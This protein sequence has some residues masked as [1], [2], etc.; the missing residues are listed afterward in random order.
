MKEFSAQTGGRY[1]YADDLENLQD[2]ALAFAQIFDD[3]D[4]FIVSGCE[5]AGSAISAGYVFLN[6]KLRHFSGSADITSW[7]QYIYEANS[8]ENIPYES[9]GSKVGRNIYGCAIAKTV[10]VKQDELT[11][12][13]IQSIAISSTGGL[14]MKDAFIGKYAL[15]LDPESGSQTVNSIVN[16]IKAINANSDFTA[17]KSVTIKSGAIKTEFSYS[18]ST[19]NVKYTG[20]SNNYRLSLID[21]VGFRFYADE[22]LIATIGN[23]SIDFD[24]PIAASE[25]EFG[26]LALTGNHFYQGAAN[27]ISEIGINVHGYKGGDSQFRNTNIGNGKGKILL[28]IT[29]ADGTVN[30]FGTTKIEAGTTD[31]LVLKANALKDNIGLTNAISWRDS[32]NVAM[33]SVGFLSTADQVFSVSVPSYNIGITGHATVDIGPAIMENGELLSEKY[34]LAINFATEFNKKANVEDV[35]TIAQANNTFAIKTDGLSQFVSDTVTAADCRSHIGAVG[36]NDLQSYAKLTNYLSDMATTDV[37]KKKIRDNIG[38]AGV[39]DFQSKLTDSGWKLIKD[40]LY[41]RQIGNIVC[42]QGATRTVHSGTVF[43]IPNTIA[44]PSHAVKHSIA[45]SNSRVWACKIAAGQRACTVVYCNGS[46]GNST[47][48]SI[49]YMA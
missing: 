31:G 8:S 36:S 44:P 38:A 5:I 40:S 16:F 26:G 3:C 43:T 24:K 46:C 48:F 12:K 17:N 1:T 29:G 15:L 6:G 30:M 22:V 23:T 39:A 13:A 20:A 35:Y 27:A 10:P 21:G 41:V 37:L 25:G 9:G 19:L 33:A 18:G 47:E 4:N 45:F 42:I 32:A 28:N 11:G 49:T 7:P 14:R 34:V 2:L